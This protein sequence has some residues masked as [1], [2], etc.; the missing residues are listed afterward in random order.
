MGAA[1]GGGANRPVALIDFKAAAV[2]G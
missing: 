2:R 1:A